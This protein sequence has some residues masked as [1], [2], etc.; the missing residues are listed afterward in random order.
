M[1]QT[2]LEDL[3]D[4]LDEDEGDGN[5]DEGDGD[6]DEGGEEPVASGVAA[7]P[8]PVP[9]PAP[10]PRGRPR[11][12]APRTA[13]GA[14]PV[15]AP[16][17]GSGSVFSTR[18]V[19][20]LWPEI[21]RETIAAGHSPYE[22]DI[23]IKR[24]EPQEMLIGSPFN[25]GSVM[26]TENTAA[27]TQIVNKI[28]D[29]YHL[30]SGANGPSTYKVE[31]LWRV[32][33]QLIKW[34]SIRLA[35][36]EAIMAMRRAQQMNGQQQGMPQPGM[37]PAPAPHYPGAYPSPVAPPG[38]PYNGFGYAPPPPP[39]SP[40]GGENAGLMAE[41]SYLRGSLTE[42]LSAAREG[43]A[44]NIQP[45][46]PAPVHESPSVEA[47]AQRVAEILRPGFGAPAAAGV[48][49]PPAPPSPSA[50]VMD[51]MTSMMQQI[52]QE[53]VVGV[54]G[55]VG[56]SIDSAIRGDIG[57]GAAPAEEPS[58]AA[59]VVKPEDQLPF[60]VVPIPDS[61]WS[62][63]RTVNF[64]K[65][66]ET[67]NIDLAGSLMANPWLIEKMGDAASG[68]IGAVGEVVKT[69]G[70]S[71]IP[72][73][74]AAEVVTN[75]PRGAVN[76]GAGHVQPQTSPSPQTAPTPPPPAAPPKPPVQGWYRGG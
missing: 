40:Q 63:G 57:L 21:I 23:R 73:P 42:A 35:S 16:M 13:M 17:K 38:Y 64:T 71:Q 8:T 54:L 62:D 28:T 48:G 44:P 30:L 51:K 3:P 2:T 47:I 14:P 72:V 61:K 67:G 5:E 27:A 60:G 59:E 22:I 41:L 32:N 37:Y 29:E 36:P 66:K 75:I 43:R 74:G 4:L 34:G 65:N 26:G 50:P 20:N 53:L 7:P 70:K 33:S 9:L 56:K 18:D 58:E 19:E 69:M 24:T 6:D 10:R 49:A 25:G 31:F 15:I 76:V 52:T 39:A 68:L 46:P 45:P 11:K 12:N 55:K 1:A